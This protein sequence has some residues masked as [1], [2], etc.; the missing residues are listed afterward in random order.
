MQA[1]ILDVEHREIPGLE[2]L[3]EFCER[4][5][6]CAG[7]DALGNPR[8]QRRRPVAAYGMNEPASV[9]AE[10]AIRNAAE[11]RIVLH[12]HVLEHAHRH[13]RVVVTGDVPIVLFDVFDLRSHAFAHGALARVQHLLVRNIEGT[14][15]HTVVLRHVQGE[16]APAEA[17]F[18]NGLTGAQL[19]LAAHVIEL[20]DL[21]FVERGVRGGVIRARVGHRA[22]EPERIEL[23]AN[24][25]VVM[26]VFTRTGQR[27]PTQAMR[28]AQNGAERAHS[29]GLRRRRAIHGLDELDELAL[30]GDA[31]FAVCIA[32]ADVRILDEADQCGAICDAYAADHRHG[33]RRD[34]LSGPE[35]EFDGWIADER[36]QSPQE[37]AFDRMT[38]RYRWRRRSDFRLPRRM[39]GA[40]RR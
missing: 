27:V 3:H 10:H 12:A 7:E 25:V 17:R 13:E 28:A 29:L 22:A 19:Q 2:D 15:F 8:M 18:D 16:T 14:H 9:A 21:R 11:R 4:R 35:H 30:D 33:R 6:I 39:A 38:L 34:A 31:S 36:Q 24:V 32:K 1:Q 20:G 26:D 37:L 40:V 23:V 5:R